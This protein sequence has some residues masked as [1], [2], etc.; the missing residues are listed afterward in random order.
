MK[1]VI[2]YKGEEEGMG[3]GLLV[4][5][6]EEATFIIPVNVGRPINLLKFRPRHFVRD[7]GEGYDKIVVE[8]Y[9]DATRDRLVQ[10]IIELGAKYGITDE[11]ARYVL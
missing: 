8:Y 3:L 4:R 9:D 6:D 10:K 5:E 2:Y 1:A 11:A 7:G